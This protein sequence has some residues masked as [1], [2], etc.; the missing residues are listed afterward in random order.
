MEIDLVKREEELSK[1]EMG[2]K[3]KDL[4]ESHNLSQ[5]SFAKKIGVSPSTIKRW[6]N[7]ETTPRPSYLLKMCRIF[8]IMPNDL[9]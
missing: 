9:F 6:E 7:C 2:D 3:I 5:Y 8:K 1:K 4:R